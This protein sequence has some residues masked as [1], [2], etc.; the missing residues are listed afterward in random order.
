MKRNILF[1]I[2]F[3][4]TFLTI[5]AQLTETVVVE[6]TYTPTIMDADKINTLPLPHT[7][8]SHHYDVIYTRTPQPTTTYTLTPT[9]TPL[10][11]DTTLTLQHAFLTA[12]YSLTGNALLQAI[13]GTEIT[14]NDQL[15]AAIT[16]DGYNQKINHCQQDDK[17][18]SRFFTT[19]AHLTYSYPLTS[20]NPSNP[21]TLLKL[22]L[23][24]KQQL[25]NYQPTH[26]ILPATWQTDKQHAE[27][28]TLRCDVTPYHLSNFFI[29]ATGELSH[30]AQ[31]YITL[32]PLGRGLSEYR[33]KIGITPGYKI[34]THNTIDLTTYAENA[35]YHNDLLT[36]TSRLHLL[37]HYRYT[38]EKMQ[39]TIGAALRISDGKTDIAPNT[40][41]LYHL[42]KT[43]DIYLHADGGE[44]TQ[45]L[46]DINSD[47]S[48]YFVPDSSTP[49]L[50]HE[51]HHLQSQVGL[52]WQGVEGLH[53]DLSIGYDKSKDRAEIIQTPQTSQYHYATI[54]Y[55]D[56]DRLFI[57]LDIDYDYKDILH[58][59]LLNTWNRW[60]TTSDY[61]DASIMW[62]PQLD[63]DWSLT[64]KI[65]S[66]LIGA[67][68]Q[69]QTF[70]E[71][72]TLYTRPQTLD[73]SAHLTYLIR[74]RL[75]IYARLTNL[76][77]TR[78]DRY[79][80]YPSPGTNAMIGLAYT[81]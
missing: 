18:Q 2:I 23:T 44:Q 54:G 31:K 62:R 65:K 7:Q 59:R 32:A 39:L 67:R 69:L 25:F 70:K 16:F 56:G 35:W 63:L 55:V 33:W 10:R 28:T 11:C 41:L 58:V 81:F 42:N 53:T 45:Y 4:N 78:Q 37:P 17:W 71:D 29:S 77:N 50:R 47:I 9:P 22:F 61:S 60:D 19:D 52:I 80:Y 73:L 26:S 51:F 68:C 79:M 40:Q 6:N 36:T 76:L 13:V 48:P 72:V 57:T 20:S 34:N 3:I 12:A 66:L 74:P 24:G 49:H 75:S 14:K 15:T 21:S 64:M 46:S 27:E 43:T 8:K 38:N 30:F 1:S 5:S